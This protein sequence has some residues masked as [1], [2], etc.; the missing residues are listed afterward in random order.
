MSDEF[1][2]HGKTMGGKKSTLTASE[3]QAFYDKFGKKQDSQGFY[4]DPALEDLIAHAGFQVS[5]KI[6]EFGCGTGK[7]AERL[8]AEYLPSSATYLGCDVSS[9]MVELAGQRLR[10]YAERAKVVQSNGTVHFPIPDDSVDH[11]VSTY[12]LDLLSEEN[13]KMVF[14]EA[15]RVLTAEGKLCLASLTKGTTILSRLVTS[16]WSTIFRMRASLV[17]GCRP[18]RLEPYVDTQRWRMEYRNILTPFGVPSEV[19]ILVKK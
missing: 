13:I 16:I 2:F 11:V 17:G 18:I 1:G 9:T 15:H 12:V 3:A 10:D 5:H 8:L 4:E 19:V 14:A 7:F 6:F